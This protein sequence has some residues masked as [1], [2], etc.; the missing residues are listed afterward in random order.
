VEPVILSGNVVFADGVRPARIVLEGA[1]I[2]TVEDCDQCPA[3]NS[4]LIFPGFIDIHVHAREFPRPSEKDRVALDAWEAA[5]RKETFSTAGYAAI[6]GGVT[7]YCAMPNDAVPPD[8][9]Q[10]YARKIETASASSCPAVLLAAITSRSEPWADLPY[11]VYLDSHPS[12]VTFTS[13]KDLEA[14]LSRYRGCRVF[15]HAEDPEILS[16]SAG[17]GP[18][19]QTRPPRAE[20]QAVERILEL[21]AK[22][23]LQTHICHVSTEEAVMTIQAYNRHAKWSVTCEATPHHLFFSVDKEGKV[24]CR[25]DGTVKDPRLLECN[26]PIRSE[27]D[28]RFLLEA[29]R[30]GLVDILATDHAPH[31]LD[32]KRRGA[33]GMPH[34]DTLGAFTGWLMR[35][36]GFSPVR[37]AEVLSSAPARVISRDL[38]RPHGVLGHGAAASFSILDLSGETRVEGGTINGRGPLHT[39]CG[40]SPFSE[41]ALPALVKATIVLG[42]QYFFL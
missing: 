7:Q 40:W 9:E 37:I 33:A 13:W 29:L 6:N 17:S 42:K 8:D 39:R 18:R 30:E 27:H 2:R 19:W 4:E 16:L 31:T 36:C 10:S 25:C 11:K 32:D 15:F 35:D 14:A 24:S 34:L 23:D 38:T 12:T 28:R 26:P 5:T 20:I 3:D 22:F 21:T 41:I 1:T